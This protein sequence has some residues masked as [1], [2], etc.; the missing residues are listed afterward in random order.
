VGISDLIDLFREK[1]DWTTKVTDTR[2]WLAF[3]VEERDRET[4]KQEN[5]YEDTS[6]KSGGQKAKLHHSRL[7]SCLPIRHCQGSA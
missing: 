1:P 7:R 4:G 6:G 5:I 2:N 3:A